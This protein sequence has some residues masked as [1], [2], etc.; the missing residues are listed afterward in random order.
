MYYIDG[1]GFQHKYNPFDEAKS[2]KI[3]AWRKRD[4]GLERNCTVKG[5]HVGSGGKV[6]HFMVAISYTQRVIHCEQY[7]GSINEQMIPDFICDQF[8]RTFEKNVNPAGKLF[9][10]DG[11]PSHNSKA[12]K[13]AKQAV[14]ATK[15]SIPPRS[16]DMSPIENVF[17]HVNDTL[18]GQVIEQQITFKD[19]EKYA[20]RI[21][22]TLE[23]TDILYMNKTIKSIESRTLKITQVKAKRIKY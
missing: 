5:N 7:E 23:N 4:E 8:R 9:L 18:D 1:A 10:Q 17:N 19:A 13:Q 16:P 14:G 15:F 6:L 2:I 3:M 22:S 21:K 11:D 20:A 12:V